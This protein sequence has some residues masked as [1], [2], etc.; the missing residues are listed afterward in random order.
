M[1]GVLRVSVSV[2]G[3][4]KVIERGQSLDN[5]CL[6]GLGHFLQSIRVTV[7]IFIARYSPSTPS[8]VEN[9]GV[10]RIP[11]KSILASSSE[12]QVAWFL[13]CASKRTLSA[14]KDTSNSSR[15]SADSPR[16]LFVAREGKMLVQYLS[17]NNRVVLPEQF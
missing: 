7:V 5:R 10:S 1:E 17:T 6:C 12:R 14:Y 3:A 16:A 15:L 13:Y 4:V 8:N 9:H 2:A 11:T